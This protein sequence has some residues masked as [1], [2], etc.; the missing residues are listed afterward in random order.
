MSTAAVSVQ[1]TD[2][3]TCAERI[4]KVLDDSSLESFEADWEKQWLV[5]RGLEIISEASR[6]L[7]ADLKARHPD[8]PWQKIAA[9]GNILR[10]EYQRVAAP[11]LWKLVRDDLGT[12]ETACRRELLN[13]P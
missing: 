2:I 12:L 10:H 8:I 6:R 9:I 13:M 4:R 1:L 3:V 11:V 5:Q 7:A